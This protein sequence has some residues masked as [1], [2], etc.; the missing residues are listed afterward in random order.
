MEDLIKIFLKNSQQ[1][2][3]ET[4]H[5]SE[6]LAR[7]GKKVQALQTVLAKKSRTFVTINTFLVSL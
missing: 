4:E 7:S 6:S 2:I 1:L 5:N 3:G